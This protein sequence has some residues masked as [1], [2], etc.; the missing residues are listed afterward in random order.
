MAPNLLTIAI[1]CLNLV[2]SRTLRFHSTPKLRGHTSWTGNRSSNG[3]NCWNASIWGDTPYK[4]TWPMCR[5]SHSN[6]GGGLGS[7]MERLGLSL[8]RG[9]CITVLTIGGSVTA[10][11]C[12][13][14]P[15]SYLPNAEGDAWPAQLETWLNRA[16]PC[17]GP[18]R[19]KVHSIGV[20]AVGSDYWTDQILEWKQDTD[21]ILNHADLVVV[22]AAINDMEVYHDIRADVA[23]L[24][25]YGKI[26]FFTELVIRQLLQVPKQPAIIYAELTWRNFESAAQKDGHGDAA[27]DHLP[28]LQHYGVD[29]VSM[30]NA[31]LPLHTAQK[32]QW[33]KSVYFTDCCHPSQLGHKMSAQAIGYALLQYESATSRHVALERRQ[34]FE[35]ETEDEDIP[36]SL[37]VA[38]GIASRYDGT[39]RTSRMRL[40]N[41]SEIMPFIA[42]W[43]VGFSFAEDVPGKPGL[44]AYKVGMNLELGIPFKRTTVGKRI[45]AN[46][47]LLKSYEH[48]GVVNVTLG[49]DAQGPNQKCARP[50]SP[51]KDPT[52]A[53][54]DCLW[55][56]NISVYVGE[57][58]MV[59]ADNLRQGCL[60]VHFQVV[61]A[62]AARAENKVKLIDLTVIA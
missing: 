52:R 22:E 46:I 1:V 28:V 58:L 60:R 31:F 5:R 54:L 25:Y 8:R 10:G 13:T 51:A 55:N 2:R 33:M 35:P 41:E 6:R 49:V 16:L 34:W 32:R 20:S 14:C 48:M 27:L 39:A 40:W 4:L 29:Q 38:E 11:R 23:G 18:G 26:H 17:A 62:E 56:K 7:R 43:S 19:H 42:P 15:G 36:P 47:G 21:H 57:T 24:G 50:S 37:F 9:Q 59:D 61:P 12:L 3:T 45:M 53:S 44:L 30:I